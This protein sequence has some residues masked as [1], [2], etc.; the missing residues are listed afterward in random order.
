MS[1]QPE[2]ITVLFIFASMNCRSSVSVVSRK[3]RPQRLGDMFFQEQSA[4]LEKAL[5]GVEQL[6]CSEVS[7]HAKILALLSKNHLINSFRSFFQTGW[8]PDAR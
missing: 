3:E 6:L 1:A 4:T 2:N 5:D 7:A 8:A